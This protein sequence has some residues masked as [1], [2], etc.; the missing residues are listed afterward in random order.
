[1]SGSDWAEVIAI[2]VWMLFGAMNLFFASYVAQMS[3]DFMKI[4]PIRGIEF[5]D[6]LIGIRVSGGIAILIGIGFLLFK[7]IGS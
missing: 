3:E 6:N 5:G 4:I 1:M 7:F 2:C